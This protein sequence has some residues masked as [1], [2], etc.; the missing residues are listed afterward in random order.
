MFDSWEGEN[1]SGN[2]IVAGGVDDFDDD[3]R[4]EKPRGPVR[5]RHK[6]KKRRNKKNKNKK[7]T[8][9]RY[10]GRTR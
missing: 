6:K 7:R 3:R 9:E 2:S 1:E 10:K 4:R 8:R 5:S